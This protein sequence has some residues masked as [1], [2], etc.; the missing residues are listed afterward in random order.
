MKQ[1]K[2]IKEETGEILRG[3]Y[4]SARQQMEP[5]IP[6]IQDNLLN[7]RPRTRIFICLKSTPAVMHSKFIILD[8]VEMEC[9]A[10]KW[11]GF[12]EK[13]IKYT[14]VPLNTF[15]GVVKSLTRDKLDWFP[16]MVK[17]HPKMHELIQTLMAAGFRI[18][19]GDSDNDVEITIHHN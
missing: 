11:H 12:S 6:F 10:D 19:V 7:G 14:E 3:Q 4:E 5:Y 18:S 8:F 9:F 1:F 15:I 16:A 13:Q 2:A 17:D